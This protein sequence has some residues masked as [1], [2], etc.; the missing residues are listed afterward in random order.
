MLKLILAVSA[1]DRLAHGPDDDMRWTGKTDKKVF[2]LLTSVG[3]VCGVGSRTWEL[4]PELPGRHV[5]PLSRRDGLALRKRPELRP[6]DYGSP[7]VD[8]QYAVE[9]AMTL[10]RFAHAHPSGWLLGGPTVAME[11]LSCGM[12]DQ[13][14]MC[15]SRRSIDLSTAIADEVTPWL[16]SRGER[17]NAGVPWTVAQ[18]IQFDDLRV[19][20]WSR[21]DARRS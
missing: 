5:I 6:Y 13:V 1:D 14:F 18:R 9:H 10:G 2:Q 11:A 12:V 4:M 19:D 3:A 16:A 7:P 15:R 17:Q 8:L 20:C 21:M